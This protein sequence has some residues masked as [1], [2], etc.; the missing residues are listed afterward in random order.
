MRNR[1]RHVDVFPESTAEIAWQSGGR[2]PPVE[3]VNR[4]DVTL[5]VKYRVKLPWQERFVGLDLWL[6]DKPA[7]WRRVVSHAILP[8]TRAAVKKWRM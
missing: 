4:L 5:Q 8:I 7:R 6:L 3:I 1:W 2:L